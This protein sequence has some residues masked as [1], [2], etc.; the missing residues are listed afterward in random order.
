M[1]HPQA[2]QYVEDQTER[3][4]FECNDWY[5]INLYKHQIPCMRF[6]WCCQETHRTD[7]Q[8]DMHSSICGTQTCSSLRLQMFR[9]DT[10]DRDLHIFSTNSHWLSL[11]LNTFFLSAQWRWSKWLTKS[12]KALRYFKSKG[13]R[14]SWIQF[15]F[16]KYQIP[17]FSCF[18]LNGLLNI[19]CL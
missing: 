4:L 5:I 15:I 12:R 10:D 16:L 2:S 3:L 14:S 19:W 9:H 6:S 11:I 1:K 18:A 8:N 7:K 17:F 13:V